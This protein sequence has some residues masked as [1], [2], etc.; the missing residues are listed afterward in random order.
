MEI[1]RNLNSGSDGEVTVIL[2][3]ILCGGCMFEMRKNINGFACDH[4]APTPA[5]VEEPELP[6]RLPE[7]MDEPPV[8]DHNP[9]RAQV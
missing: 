5:P 4:Q 3:A 1:M 9:S 2:T 7:P 8:P 6:E